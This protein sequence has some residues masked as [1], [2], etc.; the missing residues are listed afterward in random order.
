LKQTFA[1]GIRHSNEYVFARKDGTRL[2]VLLTSVPIIKDRRVVG[3][4][5]IAIDLTERKEMEKR[6][7]EKERLATIG[8]TAGMVGH[9]I[10]NP[11]QA[12]VG[13]TFL[14]RLDLNTSTDNISKNSMLESLDSIDKN[15]EYINK[16]VQDLQD[17][18]K[19]IILTPEETDFE[20]VIRDV[21]CEKTIPATI[22]ASFVIQK[23]TSKIVTDPAVLKRILVNLVNNAIQAMPTGGKLVIHTYKK[24]N[25][26]AITVEDTGVGIPDEIKPKL[27]TPL[28]TTKSKGQGFGLAVV[29]RMTE[30]LGGKVSFESEKDKGTKFTIE[31]PFN[32]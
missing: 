12:I 15:V 17:Y 29:K 7:S 26:I 28:F 10:R 25:N 8:V 3:A 24:T 11:L 23:T 19:P 32:R 30:A 18:T 27:F 2:P 31:L 20:Q 13:D 4:R 14:I 16:I 22:D 9:D 21:L 5:G 1:G 6:L